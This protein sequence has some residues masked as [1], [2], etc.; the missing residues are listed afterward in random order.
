MNDRNA[1]ENRAEAAEVIR[2]L[3]DRIIMT[4]NDKGQLEIDLHGDLAG[5][6]SMATN[7]DKPL[8]E[9]DPPVQQVKMVAGERKHREHSFLRVTV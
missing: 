7:K 1:E 8:E 6:L 3:V 4:P 5:I 9:S 2:S